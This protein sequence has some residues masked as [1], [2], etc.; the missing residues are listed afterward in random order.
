MLQELL[1]SPV[2]SLGLT[3]HRNIAMKAAASDALEHGIAAV[4]ASLQRALPS[5]IEREAAYFAPAAPVVRVIT[6]GAA[7]AELL[8][9]RAAKTCGVE[10]SYVIP[11]PW[12]EYRNDFPPAAAADAAENV[13]RAAAL[14]E[15]PGRRQEGPRAYERAKEVMLANIDL[16]VAVWDGGFIR[17]RGDTA[18]VVQGAVIRGLPIIVIDPQSPGAPSILALPPVDDFAPPAASDLLRRPLPTDL[19]GL[20]DFVHAILSPPPRPVQRQ[21]IADLFAETPA[22]TYWR[23]EYPLLLKVAA[24]RPRIKRWPAA[25]PDA[26]R[27]PVARFS[28]A[29]ASRLNAVDQ[30][31]NTIDGL[32]V[33]YGRKFRSSVVSKYLVVILGTWISGVIGLLV[34]ALS[35]ASIVVQLVA[36]ALVLADATFRTRQR[37]QERWLDYRVVAERL[38]WLSFR[39]SFGLGP[40]RQAQT[41]RRRNSSWTDWYVRRM[42][43]ALGPPQG[44]IDA[45]S[46]AAAADQMTNGEIPDQIR[47][48]RV[49][50]RQ[51]GALERRLSLTAHAALV[52]AAGVAV[53]LGIEALWAGSLDSVTWKDFAIVLL[54]VLPATMTGLN[55]LR[56][57]ADLIR[58]V[59]RSAQTIALLFRARR[60]IL[61]APRDYDHVATGMQQLAAIMGNELAD[62]RFV[63]ESRR[64]REGRRVMG[65]KPGVLG[66]S[67]RPHKSQHG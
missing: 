12:A 14:L 65:K 40:G 66:V 41:D 37:W 7:G 52:A 63:I 61:S 21:G 29:Y 15:L 17:S 11:F 18:D 51:L 39:S 8:G 53:L 44:N 23:F 1:P 42:A 33:Q 3:G 47:Y 59:E 24:G 26:G 62:W 57:D 36:N 38:R 67:L 43:Q 22:S 64:S 2:L 54:A 35:S 19:A 9:V 30:V 46:I 45:A 50:V 56:V 10:I 32:A 25:A 49:T 5:A 13:P 60:A 28:A 58:L 27:A 55:G 20:V 16:L 4:L 31:R 34:P 48:H 6:T